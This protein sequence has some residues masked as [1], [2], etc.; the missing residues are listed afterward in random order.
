MRS[1]TD[2]SY[3]LFGNLRIN[4]V[5]KRAQTQSR[6]KWSWRLVKL[7][8]TFWAALMGLFLKRAPAQWCICGTLC[9]MTFTFWHNLG[10]AKFKD[11]AVPLGPF[12]AVMAAVIIAQPPPV[13][14]LCQELPPL[15]KSRYPSSGRRGRRTEPWGTL[16]NCGSGLIPECVI[17]KGR[18]SYQVVLLLPLFPPTK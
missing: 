4:L 14:H 17:W 7:N 16:E 8:P 15:T 9:R 10:E 2:T 3:D 1:F 12:L 5:W 6:T 18:S 13:R 11:R